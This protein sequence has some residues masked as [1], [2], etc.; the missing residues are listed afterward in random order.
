MNLVTTDK[1]V[2]FTTKTE[3]SIFFR[4]KLLTPS[5]RTMCECVVEQTGNIGDETTWKEALLYVASEH[6]ILEYVELEEV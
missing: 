3:D 1:Y 4:K 2:C 6:R 5:E